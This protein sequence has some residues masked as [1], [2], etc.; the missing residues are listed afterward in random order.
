M[1]FTKPSVS[2]TTSVETQ[3]AMSEI[4]ALVFMAKQ[5]PR[6]PCQCY[7][8]VMKACQ[9]PKLAECALYNYPRGGASVTGP[10]IRL[11]EMLALEWGN[12]IYGYTELEQT[13]NHTVAQAYAWNLESNVRV[14]RVVTVLHERSTKKGTVFLTDP[15][16]IYEH[17]ANQM[18]RRVRACILGVIPGDIVESAV[19]ACTVTMNANVDITP[20]KISILV[21]SFSPFGITK[22]II[23]KYI[24]R[25]I[26]AITPG[27]VV[28]LRM[29][30]QSLKDG[31][32]KPEDFFDMRVD[33]KPET[34]TS[35]KVDAMKNQLLNTEKPARR[36]RKSAI[37]EPEKKPETE[38]ETRDFEWYMEA[39]ERAD[40]LDALNAVQRQFA[41]D[42]ETTGFN[43]GDYLTIHQTLDEKSER[44][45][46]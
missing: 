37:Q 16:D 22:S 7:D 13:R 35:P 43:D 34:Q 40:N 46:N 2:A 4:Q 44:L 15:R 5:F 19:K 1:P 21:E 42:T 38:P 45:G 33:V 14:T 39:I 31:V 25:S 36:G 8:N 11:A 23:E 32:G 10:S 3:R 28:K 9:R 17:V 41:I 18:A 12:I 30:F 6:D 29:I 26:E 27:N 24:Q 20:E